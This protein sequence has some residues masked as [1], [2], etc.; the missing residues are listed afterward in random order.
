MAD[1]TLLRLS[2][3]SPRRRKTA[4]ETLAHA[5]WPG[6][7]TRDSDELTEA[8]RKVPQFCDGVATTLTA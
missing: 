6:P 5:P 8:P 3:L 1:M 7:T 4:I 2:M